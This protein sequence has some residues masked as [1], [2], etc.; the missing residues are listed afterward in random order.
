MGIVVP[1]G[2]VK[3][4][5]GNNR[6]LRGTIT[7]ENERLFI[8]SPYNEKLLAEIK[9]MD[10]SRWHGYE[11]PPRKQWSV[12]NNARN[13]FQL[14]YLT[15]GNPYAHFDKPLVPFV[16]D[17]PLYESQS[18]ATSFMETRR[19]CIYAGEMGIGKT[20]AAIAVMERSKIF[21]G[22]MLW[23]GPRSALDSVRYE[24]IK[25]KSKVYPKFVTYE[26]LKKMVETWTPGRPAPRLL[27][28]DEASRIK[29][30]TAQRS[31]AARVITDAMRAEYGYDSYIVL[32]TGTPA[33]KD[34]ADWFNLAEV[35]CPGFIKEGNVKNSNVA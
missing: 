24:F 33:P 11:D 27:I 18:I 14:F 35:A 28:F 1:I 22:D 15:G 34:P 4:R 6:L 21:D 23:V 31:Q 19:H 30:Y 5:V 8:Q 9:S 12:K 29:N 13:H 16:S 10:G 17:R 2:E 32:M 26:E 7:L 20:L 25:W 3:F